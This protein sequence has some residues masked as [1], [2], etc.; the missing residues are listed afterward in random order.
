M[1]ITALLC[2][3]VICLIFLLPKSKLLNGIS[4]AVVGQAFLESELIF[5]LEHWHNHASTIVECPNGDLLVCWF[6]GSG[7][8][9]ADDVKI[10]GARLKRGS[11]QWSQRFTMADTP[12]YPDTNCTMFI[13]PRGRL[14]LMW[15]TILA[16]EWHTA[17]MKYK[18][19]SR[20]QNAGAPIWQSSEILHIT[21]G[22]AFA[23]EVTRVL[24]QWESNQSPSPETPRET[25]QAYSTRVRKLAADKLGRRIGWMTRAHPFVL[26]NQRLIVPLYSDGFS[27]SLMAIT[28]DWGETW[29]TS[30]PLVGAGNIQPSIVRR[31]DG[32]LFTLMRD[33]GPQP[34]RLMQ[35]ESRDNGETWSPVIDSDLPNPGSGA[36]VISLRNGHWAL[37]YNDTE[38][39]RHSLA[40]AISDDEGKSW[41]WKRHLENE[42][43]GPEAGSFHYPSI[44]QSR[45]GSLH[46]SYSYHLNHSKLEKDSAGKPKRKTIKHAHFNEAWV[47]AGDK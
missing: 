26:N 45:D 4:E 35:S 47:M 10:E 41:R 46:A 30:K 15:P 38:R 19:S 9:Q 17:L 20:Y 34:K 14:W 23:D 12:G 22:Q 37:I 29:K 18:I 28:D 3:T 43:P 1:K 42:P 21:P 11:R 5:P 13:D 16:N 6:N 31:K 44:I 24:D 40:V 33:N 8:R 2:V 39:G 36:E 7:E 27:F 32:T 25:L